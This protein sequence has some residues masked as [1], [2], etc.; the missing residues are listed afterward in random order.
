MGILP[1]ERKTIFDFPRNLKK[2]DI[3][4]IFSVSSRGKAETIKEALFSHDIIAPIINKNDIG[5]Y[6]GKYVIT[7][8]DLQEGLYRENLIIL[9]DFE[10][11]AEKPFKKKK[12]LSRKS[13]LTDLR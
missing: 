10:L 11:F 8:S 9:T 4:I 1:N 7:I 5:I 13:R 12:Q 3:P 6:S 2:L